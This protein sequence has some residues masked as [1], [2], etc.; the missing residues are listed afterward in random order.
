[1]GRIIRDKNEYF[2]ESMLR[3][4][5]NNG[6]ALF[7]AQLNHDLSTA[8]KNSVK[9]KRELAG[10]LAEVLLWSVAF[11]TLC[12]FILW[13]LTSAIHWFWFHSLW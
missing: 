5:V 8:L 9:R 12:A 11:T 2:E 4:P 10:R 1:M 13:L 3:V 7:N 6:R